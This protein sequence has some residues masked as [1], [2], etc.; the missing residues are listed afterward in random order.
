MK[1]GRLVVVLKNDTRSSYYIS[2][3]FKS[4]YNYSIACWNDKYHAGVVRRWPCRSGYV[5][6]MQEWHVV[7]Y[8]RV[9]PCRSGYKG[10]QE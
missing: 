10:I 4:G 7:R 2:T 3:A 8:A 6:S 1:G 5:Y 9:S